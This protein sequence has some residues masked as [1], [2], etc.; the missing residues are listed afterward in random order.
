MAARRA[1]SFRRQD[2]GATREARPARAP[3]HVGRHP[4]LAR[5]PRAPPMHAPRFQPRAEN[6][7]DACNK[8]APMRLTGLG[9]AQTMQ[10]Q[11]APSRGRQRRTARPRRAHG[12][13]CASRLCCM[14][15]CR[16]SVARWRRGRARITPRHVPELVDRPYGHGEEAAH[17]LAC[18][19]LVVG[20]SQVKRASKGLDVHVGEAGLARW[21]RSQLAAATCGSPLPRHPKALEGLDATAP[22]GGSCPRRAGPRCSLRPSCTAARA[23]RG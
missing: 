20:G 4:R 16:S 12:G 5:R 2:G 11:S 9:P 10:T 18:L 21:A 6:A 19:L 22:F 1:R 7:K 23:G 8:R 13:R 17:A 15:S 14:G 3:A